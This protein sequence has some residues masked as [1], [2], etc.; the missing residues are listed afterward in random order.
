MNYLSR[1]KACSLIIDLGLPNFFI[2]V[3]NEKV[4]NPVDLHFACSPLYYLT[5]EDQEAYGLVN[6]IPL[7]ASNDGEINY[8]YDIEKRDFFSFF[9]E[10]GEIGSRYNWEQLMEKAIQT[11]IEL[12][13][14][15]DIEIAD[16]I[17]IVRQIYSRLEVDNLITQI[18][19]AV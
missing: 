3:I 14:D 15:P 2:D 1:E 11:S 12:E 7:W 5:P 18:S 13:S 9:L 4:Q 10:D 6:I 19:N 17:E 8:I 16:V